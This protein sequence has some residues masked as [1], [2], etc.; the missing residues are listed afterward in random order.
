MAE[1]SG[2]RVVVEMRSVNHRY[3][4]LKVRGAAVGPGVVDRISKKIKKRVKRGAVVLTVRATSAVSSSGVRI[5]L[6]AARRVLGELR[7]LEQLGLDGGFSAEFVCSQPGVLVQAEEVGDEDEALGECADEAAEACIDALVKMRST[8][9]DS[10]GRDFTSRLDTLAE[11]AD[12]IGVLARS[13]PEDAQTR[14]RERL[15]RLLSHAGVEIGPERIA[16]EVAILADKLDVTEE[17]VRVTSHI[18]QAR[19]LLTKEELAIGRR[20]DFLVQELVREY[21]TVASKSQSAESARLV[22]EAKAELESVREQVQNI[23]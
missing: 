2:H 16:Q 7:Q 11:L 3:L 17:L 15:D 6:L 12:K 9:G 13:A 4:D 1:R 18:E 14:L 19:E 21:N 20:L 5:D 8:E 23:E 10:I 22:V